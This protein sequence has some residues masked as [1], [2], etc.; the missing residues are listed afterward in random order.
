VAIGQVAAFLAA[1][2]AL[3]FYMRG[4]SRAGVFRWGPAPLA[5]GHFWEIL[6]VGLLACLSPLQTV[7]IVLVVTGLVAR[8]GVDALAGYGIGAR[9]EFML[10]PIAFGV[11][12][13][14]VPM[15][16]MAVGRGDFA[17]ARRIAWTAAAVATSVLGAIGVAV[18]IWPRLWTGLFRAEPA[19]LAYAEE[20]LRWAGPGY[21]F[22]GTGLAL[23]F[24][25]QGAG[26][27]LGPVLGTSLRMVIVIAG[28]SLLA[29]RQAPSWT[30]FALI[31]AAMVVYGVFTAA[32]LAA[33]DWKPR[34]A[35]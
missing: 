21:A 23:F 4:L 8:I 26:R 24:A 10:I 3:F 15:V 30:Y 25:M 13:A 2:V 19:V 5:R 29:A 6:R 9:L 32:T 22:F 31:G 16:G 14:A 20:Y 34:P 7:V 18:A 17:R 12:V 1:G 27:V 35:R 28:G 33:S 11:G